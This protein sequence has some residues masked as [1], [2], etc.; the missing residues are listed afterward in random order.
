MQSDKLKCSFWVCGYKVNAVM[1][2][3]DNKAKGVSFTW[4]KQPKRMGRKFA[5]EYRSRRNAMLKALLDTLA[6]D[7]GVDQSI[8]IIDD[9]SKPM[10]ITV[11]FSGDRQTHEHEF[12]GGDKE[13]VSLLHGMTLEECM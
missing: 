8:L 7:T 4:S 10:V 12:V 11:V 9:F 13:S 6:R 1:T 3:V 5:G 2:V